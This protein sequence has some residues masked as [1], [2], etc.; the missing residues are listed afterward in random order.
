[1]TD[2]TLVDAK[3]LAN[4]RGISQGFFIWL[5]EQGMMGSYNGR[6][7]FPVH[8]E[9]KVAACHY[10][11]ENGQWFYFPK[12]VGVQPLIFGNINGAEQ[13]WLFESPWDAFAAMDKFGWHTSNSL[14]STACFVTRGAGNGKLISGHPLPSAVCYAFTQNDNAGQTWLKTVAAKA[15][16]PVVHVVI[17]KPHKDLNEWTK[18]GATKV[19][20]EAAIKS[21][22]PVQAQVVDDFQRAVSDPRPKIR[23]PGPDRLLSD[24]ATELGEV[25]HHKD[26]FNRK[27]EIVVLVDNDLKVMTP[28]AFRSWAEKYFVGYRAKAVGS[29]TI[30]FYM[31]MSDSEAR[32]TMA[33]PQFIA[34]L[35]PVHRVNRAQLPIFV[36]GKLTLLPV[37]Y[38]ESTRTLTIADVCYDLQM[39]VTEATDIIKNLL[40]EF[41]FTDGLRSM[42]VAVAAMVSLFATQMLPTGCLRPCFIFVAN[43]EGAGKT[44]LATIC[45]LPTLGSMPT[46]CK[47]NDDEEIRKS[48]TTAVRE[49]RPVV[50]LDNLKSRLSSSALE[51]FLSAP[52][53]TDRKLGVNETVTGENLATCFVTGNGM[54]VSPDMRRRSLF[55]ELHLE[56]ERAED[57]QFEQRLDLQTLL[58]MRPKLLA[59]LWALVKHWDEK[60]RPKPSR[61]HSAFPAWADI[62]AG[63]VEASGL[64]CPL[65]AAQVSAAADLE[66]DDM[67]KLAPAMAK[68]LTAWSF[69][70]LVDLARENGLFEHIIGTE[71]EEPGRKEKSILGRLLARYD[72][73][74]VLEYRFKVQGQG[75]NR[76]YRVEV[77]HGDMV[78]NGVSA[79]ES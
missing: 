2:F 55:I 62:V 65:E 16:C 58:E 22:S 68:K 14:R 26:I 18:A 20:I 69:A 12:G 46:G 71:K 6:P 61:S 73:R 41:C 1:V 23:L 52:T 24:F 17:P 11:D 78:C 43:A 56:V 50:F 3:K 42:S 66:A 19:D 28:Q 76:R 8:R 32:G 79:D 38:H 33:S 4:W 63:I 29:N 34:Q 57:R 45:I 5:H 47:S 25:L 75:R 36:S 15:G 72:N 48:L 77:C 53:W 59:A 30:E 37:G 44:L 67:R 54:T 49:A 7:A 9:G 40:A 60:G 39:P 35:R 74:L 64:S 27:G 70:E 31:T 51:A 10:K 21:A 13:I